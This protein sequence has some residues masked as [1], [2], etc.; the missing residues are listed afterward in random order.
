MKKYDVII[1]GKALD[2]NKEPFLNFVQCFTNVD[3][4]KLDFFRLLIKHLDGRISVNLNYEESI[5]DYEAE[6]KRL[7]EK[8]KRLEKENKAFVN[9]NE[10]LEKEKDI[11]NMIIY[12]KNQKIQ[13]YEATIS[14]K[15]R[16]LKKKERIIKEL[17]NKINGIENVYTDT[18]SLDLLD[19]LI[20]ANK[21]NEELE[22]ENKELNNIIEALKDTL[23]NIE[24]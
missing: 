22:K 9:I 4:N 16:R 6:N 11:L 24:E 20:I 7:T 2:V 18:D 19:T 5:V 12:D 8:N 1:T 3:E 14:D 23:N 21:T 13:Q 17:V 10:E 15:N